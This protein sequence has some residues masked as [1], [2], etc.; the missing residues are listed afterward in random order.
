MSRLRTADG[1]VVP[2]NAFID[3]AEAAGLMPRIDNL[4]LFRAVQVVR[5]LQLKSREVGIFC[6][7]SAATLTDAGQFR[8]FLKIINTNHTQDDTHTN[9][10]TQ[11]TNHR[12]GPLE[13]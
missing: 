2:A 5:R 3:A 8:Q 11:S 6:N 1:D 12:N 7:I 13:Q 9:E 4:L 10:N